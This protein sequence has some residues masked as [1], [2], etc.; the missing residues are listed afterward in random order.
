VNRLV[1]V[2]AKRHKRRLCQ[3]G[4]GLLSLIVLTIVAWTCASGQ[5][6]QRQ[7]PRVRS[8]IWFEGFV[9]V[10]NPDVLV[11]SKETGRIDVRLT[12][13]AAP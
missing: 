4:A 3:F 13:V 12:A 1:V 11:R 6:E 8:G 2:R 10:P 5:S 9:I 7:M